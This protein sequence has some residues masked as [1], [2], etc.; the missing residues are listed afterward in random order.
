MVSFPLCRKTHK[1]YI[2]RNLKA[3]EVPVRWPTEPGV[4]RMWPQAGPLS[5]RLN[6]RLHQECVLHCSQ[7]TARST[8]CKSFG[9]PTNKLVGPMYSKHS[10]SSLDRKIYFLL[11]ALTVK[12]KDLREKPW[13]SASTSDIQR[14]VWRLTL[15]NYLQKYLEA[16]RKMQVPQY[17]CKLLRTPLKTTRT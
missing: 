13:G 11:R 12:I 2:F 7:H 5:A 1:I 17:N 14:H 15:V 3:P 4:I 10:L 16:A 8:E 6:S 9:E